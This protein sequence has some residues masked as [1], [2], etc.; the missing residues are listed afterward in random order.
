MI[1]R[2]PGDDPACGLLG[3][4][5]AHEVIGAADLERARPLQVLRFNQNAPADGGIEI[6]IFNERGMDGDTVEAVRRVFDLCR[7]DHAW[8]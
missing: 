5:P 8:P 1:A 7:F 6:R 3:R 2:R 4:Q